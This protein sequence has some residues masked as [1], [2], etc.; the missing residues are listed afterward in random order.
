[1]TRCIVCAALGYL[2]GQAVSVT[3]WWW[4]VSRICLAP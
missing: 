4:I 3:G 2:V 1:M